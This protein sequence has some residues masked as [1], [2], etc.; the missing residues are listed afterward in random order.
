ID[1]SRTMSP[2][3]QVV[4]PLRQRM[5]ED[6]RLRKLDGKTQIAYIRAV[7]RLAGFL[8]RSPDTATGEDLRRFQLHM[9]DQGTSSMTIN[10]T[11]SG[12]R[13]FFEITLGRGEL[14]AMMSPVREPRRLPVVLSREEVARL[15]AAARNPKHRAALSVAYG[16][17]LR[18]SEV[19][20]L[21]VGDV[22]SER[23]TLRVEQGK[24]RKDR[25]AMLSAVL[26]GRL[27]AG[28][29]LAHAEGK[30]L[31]NGWLFPGLDPTD[32]MTPRQLNRAIH[33]AAAAARIDK[34]VSMHSLRH[35]F[36]THLLG[37]KVDIRVIQGLLGHE[38]LETT[39]LYTQ[40]GSAALGG[41]VLRCEGCGTDQIAY[42]S[43]RNRHCPKC[44]GGAA[45]RWL[46][47]RQ[48]ELL[49]VAYYHVVFTLPAPIAAIAYHNKIVIYGLLFDVAA[50]TLLR[51]GA[52]PK[53][54]GARIGMTLVLHTWGSALTHHPHVH[55]I[56]P[57]GGLSAHGERWIGCRPGFFLPGRV[58]FRILRRR[59]LQELDTL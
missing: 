3:T 49:P 10:A 23:M 51:I 38:K 20:S 24:G 31:P 28:W 15:I 34:P 27:R 16:A 37:Q 18:A 59:V 35:A 57:G 45:R 13:F 9:V 12:L 6:M 26:L 55:G 33:A 50:E 40:C 17:G 2:S 14:M 56:V 41:H 5:I 22:D 1:R 54:L 32:P 25:Y 21:K 43:C 19:I 53:H 29:R 58:F 46:Q 8:R 7:R 30:L 36:A 44:Q 52:D 11:I 47:A 4:S 48:A 42:N 39:A